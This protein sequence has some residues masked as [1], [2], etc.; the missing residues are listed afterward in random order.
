[1]TKFMHMLWMIES[2]T[3]VVCA[4]IL[5]NIETARITHAVFI[6]R[7]FLPHIRFLSM[8]LVI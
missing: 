8:Q 3:R 1:V 4:K 5:F 2:S 6:F 7:E